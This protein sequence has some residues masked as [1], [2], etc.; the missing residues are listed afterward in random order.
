MVDFPFTYKKITDY[1]KRDTK[2]MTT[3]SGTS[4]EYGN[5]TWLSYNKY[6]KS[7]TIWYEDR[8]SFKAKLEQ[9]KKAG[10]LGYS[11]WVLGDEDPRVWDVN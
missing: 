4:K 10:V 11:V 3:G 8:D 6:G 9:V 5:I 1:N 7:Y 2:N